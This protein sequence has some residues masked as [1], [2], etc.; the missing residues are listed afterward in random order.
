MK[1][2]TNNKIKSRAK[3]HCQLC[4]TK[5]VRAHL[6]IFGFNPVVTTGINTPVVKN[7]MIAVTLEMFGPRSPTEG[8]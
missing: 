6:N 3:R 1:A 4:L 8:I 5:E 7:F 2:R